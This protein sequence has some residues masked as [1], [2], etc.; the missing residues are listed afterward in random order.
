MARAQ[1]L[2]TIAKALHDEAQRL[3]KH[4]AKAEAEALKQASYL[5]AH[6]AE[7]LA[8]RERAA[9]AAASA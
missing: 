1:E 2:D 6:V 8:E 9:A 7:Y 3:R 5:V 4:Q